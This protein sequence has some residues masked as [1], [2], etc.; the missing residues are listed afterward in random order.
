MKHDQCTCTVEV[1]PDEVDAGADIM[2][3]VIVACPRKHDL[4]GA[5]VS[6]RNQDDAELARAE[7]AKVDGEE[8]ESDNIVLA[9][10]RAV[11]EHVYRAVLIG[12]DKNGALHEQASTEVCVVVK[13]HT[14]QLNVWDVPSAIIAGERFKFMVG[15][16]CSSGC[17]LAGR[18]LSIF[19]RE[20]ALLGN[21]IL[22]DDVWPGTDALYFAEVE[23]E[24]PLTAGD[25]E[26]EVRTAE[27][28][29]EPPHAAGAFTVAG[30]VVI[31]P[32]CEV[33]IEAIDKEK[34]KP[35]KGARVVM[36]PYRATTDENGVAKVKATKGQYDLLVS[37][38]KY[39]PVCTTI[40][41]TAD[42]VTKAEL[43]VD[44][45][46]EPPDETVG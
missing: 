12:A 19:D 29:S 6:I 17:N 38:S 33:T 42:M 5:C 18:G 3:K 2:L 30:R 40:E 21:A 31:P 8:Y 36:H 13:P 16:K 11:G 32:D 26:W 37:G 43:D 4:R 7:L 46:W 39:I 28:D 24:A 25:Y 10:P 20:N 15:V 34:Q 41:V 22:G 44:P 27:W 9:A 1:S 14:V 23:A 35:I 45:P